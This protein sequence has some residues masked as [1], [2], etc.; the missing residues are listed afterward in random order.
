MTFD[1][2]VPAP[3]TASGY[4]LVGDTT[5][6]AQQTFIVRTFA[7]GL[8]TSYHR[9]YFRL[10]TTLGTGSTV[11]GTT[12]GVGHIVVLNNR[13]IQARATAGG[14]LVGST[15]LN[16]NQWYLVEMA[17]DTSGPTW[18]VDWWLDEAA[19]TQATATSQIATDQATVRV[20]L[21]SS[22]TTFKARYAHLLIGN[23]LTDDF[24]PGTVEFFGVASTGSHGPN[25]TIVTGDFQDHNS[26]NLTTS[27]T[28]SHA[29]IDE[30]P[31]TTAEHVKQVVIRDAY[32]EYNYATGANGRTPVG[33]EQV[34]AGHNVSTQAHTQK[35]QLYDGTSVSDAYA[36]TS[37]G[38]SAGTMVTGSKHWTAAPSGAWTSSLF[39]LS[40]A[41]W[42]Y[43]NDITNNPAMD[44]TWLE[45]AF[46]PTVPGTSYDPMGMSGFFGL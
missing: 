30:V 39:D 6:G 14:T 41:R 35:L 27:E 12:G 18:T 25:G 8:Q 43:S 32:L 16:L 1:N 2:S 17:V 21:A 29:Y 13:T 23:S 11:Y 33:V 37:F 28:A 10:E 40:R 9:F 26:T 20:G 38:T 34:I 15:V 22:S 4:C 24:G 46:P 44:A 31:P 5:G 42:G 19:Q 3:N 36:L 7:A 45:A